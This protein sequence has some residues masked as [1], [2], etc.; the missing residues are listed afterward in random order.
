M[1]AQDFGYSF[2]EAV[3]WVNWWVADNSNTAELLMMRTNGATFGPGEENASCVPVG[4]VEYC[5]RWY[6]R[7]GCGRIKPLNIPER[8]W[9]YVQREIFV[10]TQ[11]PQNGK[12]Y[13]AKSR[14]VIKDERNGLYTNAQFDMEMQFTEYVKDIE[15][16]WRLF[17]HEG[18]IVDFRCYS[19]DEW[20][21]PSRHFCEQVAM[22]YGKENPSFS[23]DV[24]VRGTGTTDIVELH[25]FFACG[26]YGFND[27]AMLLR[28]AKATQRYLLEKYRK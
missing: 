20:K 22:E 25:D 14:D 10:G 19:G 23:L 16:E 12:A 7:M 21:L 4:S 8:L 28:M 5:L 6:S 9:K 3:E 1:P 13:F 2:I 15:S 17:V 27:Y 18:K 24:M 26:L 11:L